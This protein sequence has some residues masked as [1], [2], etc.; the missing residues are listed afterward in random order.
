MYTMFTIKDHVP[1]HTVAAPNLSSDVI[2]NS[3]NNNNHIVKP[4][5]T[6][7]PTALSSTSK[8]NSLTTFKHQ[9][10][11]KK[12]HN[13]YQVVENTTKEK[14][15]T[16][17]TH[18][19]SKLYAP[20]P[21]PS[22]P[23]EKIPLATEY[24]NQPSNGKPLPIDVQLHSLPV[25]QPLLQIV[26]VGAIKQVT[27]QIYPVQT[28][29]QPI[30]HNNL[31]P[32]VPAAT[33]PIYNP[34]YLVTQSNNLYNHH[35]Q[36]LFKPS[37]PI[38][39]PVIETGY[40]NAD[41]TQSVTSTGEIVQDG[42]QINSGISELPQFGP[43]IAAP[44]L[45]Q[46]QPL[47]AVTF[48][49]ENTANIAQTPNQ[50]NPESDFVVSNYYSNSNNDGQQDSSQLLQAYAEEVQAEQLQQYHHQLQQQ[51]QNEQEQL[52]QQNQHQ[53]QQQQ[54]Q[55]QQQ[56]EEQQHFLLQE[57]SQQFQQPKQHI[58]QQSVQIP[59]YQT[60]AGQLDLSAAAAAFQEHERLVKQQLG[61]NT[62]LRIFV[63]DEDEVIRLSL[64]NTI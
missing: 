49:L 20:D 13:H 55:Q 27:P 54:Q 2:K 47:Q 38:A 59:V 25:A 26:D 57:E 36:Q 58:A 40:V 48:Q 61:S 39:P 30:I 63:P 64:L 16:H 19:K 3:Y 50:I 44:V 12:N 52:Q 29:L 9:D 8:L 17:E 32:L 11:L 6:Y 14:L 28:N 62:P 51:L 53:H 21:D 1:I 34:T 42:R 31:A 37:V 22:V 35:Q 10:H 60:H 45:D 56:E 43:L 23:S 33:I 7:L 15:L 46:E 24:H 18:E 41:Q 5:K 4:K